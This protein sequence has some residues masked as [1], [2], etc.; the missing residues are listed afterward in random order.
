MKW[1][2]SR[3]HRL[4]EQVFSAC[5]VRRLTG[6]D[7]LRCHGRRARGEDR[8]AEKPRLA[9]FLSVWSALMEPV[10]FSHRKGGPRSDSGDL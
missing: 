7:L 4:G 3:S 10:S 8:L 2:R 5:A 1:S 9:L 6:R